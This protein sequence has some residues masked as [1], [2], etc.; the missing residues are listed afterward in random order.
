MNRN[1]FRSS[2]VIWWLLSG[3]A[4]VFL[5]MS[6][7]ERSTKSEGNGEG[8]G[9]VI[10][11]LVVVPSPVQEGRSAV[12]DLV[13]LDDVGQP[14]SGVE[15]SFSVSPTNIGHC[16]PSVDT[17]DAN[18]SA[19]T[20]FTATS[21]GAAVIRAGIE[22]VTSKTVQVEVVA[23]TVS[24]EPLTI[25]I[26]PEVLPADGLSTGEIE[27][28]V[29]DASG[30]LAED[31]TVV[32]FTAGERFNDVDEDG[33]FT[34]G[35]DELT[36][37]A[38]QNGEWDPIG[39]IPLYAL[40]DNG[41]V[42]V[43][44][45][46]G[47]RTGTAH[48]KVT[49]DI[50]GELLQDDATLLLVPT[51]SVAYIVLMPDQ[52]VIQVRGTGGME[53]TQVR[54]ILYDDNGSRVGKDFPVEF[55]IMYGPGGGEALNGV[56][57][58]S[59]TVNT[60]S[61]GEAIVTLSS[62]TKSGVVKLRAKSGTVLSTSSIVTVC[63]G[64][65]VE[66]S[67]GVTPC[68]IRG[69]DE[70][71]VEASVCACVADMYG[72]PVPDSTSV[73]FGTEEGVVT[74]CDRTKQGCAYATYRS[75]D[76]RGDG[77]VMIWAE[78]WGESGMLADTCL[79]IISGPPASINFLIYPEW[80]WADGVHKGWVRVE[81]LDI[82]G[83]FVLDHTPVEMTTNFGSITSGYTSDGRY[84]SI[85]DTEL[86]SQ[87]LAQDYSMTYDNRDDSVGVVN[88]LTAKSGVVSNS[89]NVDFI[90]GYTYRANC[91]IF[92]VSPVPRGA[93]VPVEIIIKDAYGIPLGGHRIVG[94]QAHTA[95]GTIV[96]S[97]Y[98]NKFGQAVD[99]SFIATT[100]P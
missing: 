12:V 11:S 15:V 95:G 1:C 97:D 68:N 73:H 92:V 20:V 61:Y 99:F 47:F 71:C 36:S 16:S 22:G 58:D 54:A 67:V 86:L 79:L 43:T 63:A 70:D 51:D 38:N 91:E 96:G 90:T 77:R 93:T 29:R 57:S 37:D 94:D 59:I 72:N 76:P 25:E 3:M 64:P 53:A 6:C 88:V 33:Y 98:T 87:V 5:L 13:V 32:K 78:T 81:V 35:V 62:G 19:G 69:W 40:T 48:V 41:E 89:V 50:D 49:T 85:Y 65:P 9:V 66:I 14:L 17:T 27:V 28:T 10:T 44:Y 30:F 82:N 21:P 39:F 75:C 56:T 18:G 7:G 55:Y 84:A 83:N 45:I 74:C 2:K 8:G 23:Q 34:E 46:A 4:L 80:L 60:N 26:T 31:G 52:P 24:T 100:D 42:T